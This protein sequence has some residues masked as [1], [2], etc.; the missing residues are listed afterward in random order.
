MRV[1]S[2]EATVTARVGWTGDGV[3]RDE[4]GHV[5]TSRLTSRLQKAPERL[6]FLA[7]AV[8]PTPGTYHCTVKGCK[9]VAKQDGFCPVHDVPLRLLHN[10]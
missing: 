10:R 5:A 8:G 3:T 2:R 4:E 1:S 6:R 9:T 7:R